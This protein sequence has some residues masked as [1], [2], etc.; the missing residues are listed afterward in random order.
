V[1]EQLGDLPVVEVGDVRSGAIEPALQ[2]VLLLREVVPLGDQVLVG[3]AE[4]VAVVLDPGA[5]GLP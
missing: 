2:L 4:A 1:G 5:V 3:F